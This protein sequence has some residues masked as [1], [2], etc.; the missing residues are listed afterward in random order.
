MR[1]SRLSPVLRPATDLESPTRRLA[2]VNLERDPSSG[3]F[4]LPALPGP[5]GAGLG[6][7]PI[8]RQALHIQTP[9]QQRSRRRCGKTSTALRLLQP[10][11][12]A[13]R[14]Q[15]ALVRW[16]FQ[17]FSVGCCFFRA[18][19]A[20]VSV[21]PAS[22]ST[23]TAMAQG[24]STI[25]SNHPLRP[26]HSLP[27]I[28]HQQMESLSRGQGPSTLS[29]SAARPPRQV[30]VDSS[31]LD[32]P[33]ITVPHPKRA[34]SSLQRDFSPTARPSKKGKSSDCRLWSASPQGSSQDLFGEGSSNSHHPNSS[35]NKR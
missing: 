7:H 24:V 33:V 26:S 4:Y 17:H 22:T 29:F 5:P 34:R 2:E 10:G 30:I 27:A 23:A 31:M 25:H 28:R 3:T 35:N 20:S 18:R 19:L 8:A 13:V 12:S 9:V 16:P 14:F 11:G 1:F 6:R 15:V 32:Q 21:S